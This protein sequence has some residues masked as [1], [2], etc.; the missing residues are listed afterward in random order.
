M[1]ILNNVTRI[2]YA[3]NGVLATFAYPFEIFADDEVRVYINSTLQ[4][5]TTHYTVTGVGGDN[6]GNVVF[7]T[8]PTNGTTVTLI[9]RVNRERV[10]EYQPNS[11]IDADT[12]NTDIDRVWA[13]IQE[14][15]DEETRVVRLS[16]EDSSADLTLPLEAVRANKLMAFDADGDATV[17][18]LTVEEIEEQVGLAADQV[19]LATAQANAA[20]SSAGTATAQ[21]STATTQAGIATTQANNAAASAALALGAVGG[22][23]VTSNDTTASVLDNKIT[24]S[25]GLSKTT[26]SPG[27]NEGLQI[28]VSNEG[29]LKAKL[30]RGV[31]AAINL[32]L[33]YGR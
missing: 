14:T 26:T 32:A 25:G 23:K 24:V 13:V 19:A 4:T 8:P 17:T 7:V 28:S 9:R 11:K 2:A 18:A 6:G 33:Y 30:E 10:T 29:I 16:I 1:A 20:A 31:Q 27:G 5:L 3:A 15:A 12:L 22:V 21:A